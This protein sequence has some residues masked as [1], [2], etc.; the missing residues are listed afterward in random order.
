MDVTLPRWRWRRVCGHHGVPR[1]LA[2]R[3]MPRT[4]ISTISKFKEVFAEHGQATKPAW[5]TEAGWGEDKWLPDPNLQASFLAKFYLLH[6]SAGVAQFYWYAYDNGK[7]GTL[8]DPR[9]AYTKRVLHTAKFI[10]GLR[11]RL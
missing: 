10:N 7:W 9:M 8:S 4:I 2:G 11:V 1:L 6:W 5:D 3:T